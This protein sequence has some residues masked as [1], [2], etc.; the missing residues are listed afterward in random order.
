[1]A[2][3][4]GSVIGTPVRILSGEEEARA[5]FR[6]LRGRIGLGSGRALG[7]DLGGGSLELAIGSEARGLEWTVSLPLGVV[8]LRSR[9]VKS[10]PMTP[11]EVGAIDDDVRALLAP[12]LE[13]VARLRPSLALAAGGTARALARLLAERERGAR[14]S[15]PLPLPA[16]KLGELR[17]R[18]VG[19]TQRER[20]RMR[21]V[22]RGRADLLPTG[23]V[24]L[25]ALADT[26][27]L[28]GF[29]VS[30]WGLREGV[31]LEALAPEARRRGG[32]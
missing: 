22:R 19:S 14:I 7:L 11:R 6:S 16:K 12:H 5:I 10:D 26:L 3:R 17:D 4:I 8:L 24:V 30:D 28:E 32:A 15:G 1:V 20:L 29:T 2:R 25:A 18:L 13:D 21:G 9:H 23:A 31:M 27:G